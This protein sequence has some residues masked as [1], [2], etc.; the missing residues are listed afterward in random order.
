VNI[1]LKRCSAGDECLNPNGPMLPATNEYF[2][3]DRYQTD[4]FKSCCKICGKKRT[5]DW[6]DQN[7]EKERG[8]KQQYRLIKADEIKAYRR[9]YR[10]MNH[11]NIL[12][13]H[14][15]YNSV[16]HNK[17]LQSQRNYRHK[18]PERIRIQA[19][20]D[21]KTFHDKHPERRQVVMLNW[22]A[23]RRGLVSDFSNTD[24]LNC[25]NYFGWKC[26]ICG[27]NIKEPSYIAAP[28][29]WTPLSKGG[30]NTATNIVVL[31]HGVNGC[32]NHKAAKMP[33]DW[34]KDLLG[35]HEAEIKIKEINTY[36]Q[37]ARDKH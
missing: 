27:R 9:N 25:L 30:Q 24:W 29:H 19:V 33:A 6:R 10:L 2:S 5:K 35:E 14:R 17:V 20:R 36:F 34:L 28:D 3:K 13:K 21:R 8:Y 4:G 22:R 31:C 16:N 15:E 37:W 23:K 1:A 18:Y 11:S 32:N 26:A 12:L 7:P